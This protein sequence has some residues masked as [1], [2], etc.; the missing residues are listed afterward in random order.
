MKTKLFI[1]IAICYIA[2]TTCY[3]QSVLTTL[4]E[5]EKDAGTLHTF[6]YKNVYKTDIAGNIYIAGAT[7]NSSGNYDILLIKYNSKG[8]PQ[9]SQQYNGGANDA[10]SALTLDTNGNIYLTGSTTNSN[11]DIICFKFADDGTQTWMQTFNADANLDDYATDITLSQNN[12]IFITGSSFNNSGNTDITVLKYANDGTFN[13][14][15]H[16]NSNEELNDIGYKINLIDENV[17]IASTLQT[18]PIKYDYAMLCIKQ[19]NGDFYSIAADSSGTIGIDKVTDATIDSLGNI[20]ITGAKMNL[21]ANYD[22]YVV[23][24]DSNLVQ[25]WEQTYNGAE[26]LDDISNA[27]KVDSAGNVYITGYSSTST[28]GKNY[29]TL[30]YNSSGT[31]QWTSIYNNPDNTDD[32]ATAMTLG[33]NGKLYVTGSTHN[34]QFENDNFYTIR[35]NTTTGANTGAITWDS[36]Y[37]YNDTPTNIIIDNEQNI[38]VGGMSQTE[39]N[40]WHYVT[41]KYSEKE[42]LKPAE[43]L[44]DTINPNFSYYENKGQIITTDTANPDA[45]FVR[46]YTNNTY[47]QLYFQDNNYSMVF[48]SIDTIAATPDTLHRIDVSFDGAYKVHNNK[49]YAIDEQ[50][51]GY[52]NYFLSQ[53]P[54][55][56]TA[57]MPNQRLVVPELYKDIDLQYYSNQKGFKYCF[58]VKKGGDPNKI[59]HKFTGATSSTINANGNL[60][61]SSSIGSTNLEC[62]AYQVDNNNSIIPLNWNIQWNQV[63]SNYFSFDIGAYDSTKT[64]IIVVDEGHQSL[65]ITS[66]ANLEH[67]TYYG[68]FTRDNINDI[69]SDASG[70]VYTCGFTDDI[71]FPLAPGVN[72]FQSNNLGNYDATIVKFD[73]D[74]HLIWATY[75]GGSQEDVAFSLEI[76][77]ARNV[78][79]VGHTES[80]NFPMPST[81]VAGAYNDFSYNGLKDAY[82]VKL[83]SNAYIRQWA[84]FVGAS[85]HEQFRKITNGSNGAY[86]AVGYGT[87]ASPLKQNGNA[88]YS[89]QGGAYIVKF[90]A[91]DTITWAT[92]IPSTLYIYD[93]SI[94]K[95]LN[96]KFLIGTANGSSLPL[97]RQ[98][99]NS[100]VDSTINNYNDA[101][102]MKL[103][104][105][106]SLQWCT[107]YGG[108]L[109]EFGNGIHV[110][111]ETN[112]PEPSVYIVG[113][114]NSTDFPLKFNSGQFID[115]TGIATDGFIAKF[116]YFGARL[117]STYFGGDNLDGA[118]RVTGDNLGNIYVVGSTFSANLPLKHLNNAYYQ[119]NTFASTWSDGYIAAFN[120]AEQ[121]LWSTYLSGTGSDAPNG[122]TITPNNKLFMA[123]SS[124]VK[125]NFPWQNL[126][127]GAW[128]RDTL[129][130]YT[131]FEN[132]KDGYI[133]RL[134]TLPVQLVGI[135]EN[136]NPVQTQLLI[137]PNPN[138]GNLNVQ[139]NLSQNSDATI[140]IYSTLGQL[141]Y[142]HTL[143][144]KLGTIQEQIDVSKYANGVYFI[145]ID[146]NEKQLSAKIIKN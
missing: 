66:N 23:K 26:N 40:I 73:N 115:S 133:A 68:G 62:H 92:L 80:S 95:T 112:Q 48:A 146:T 84:S 5:W 124:D 2:A 126:G 119:T 130:G 104:P 41:V 33:N 90:N 110:R 125:Y 4:K 9:W 85:G 47:P 86:Y 132:Y 22:Y 50:K 127:N 11:A 82:V 108:S 103:A 118:Y 131:I 114:T 76:D 64:L 135:D 109:P 106:D 116:T 10:A 72:V 1:L 42:I 8:V 128:Y 14:A 45:G 69:K 18:S 37:H 20:Y 140:R 60:T 57:V 88:Y 75:Y 51:E 120:N 79:F 113:Q 123:G 19:N 29:V 12:S 143:K 27:L 36:K 24:L 107:Y 111:Q 139:F 102:I 137:Y 129:G 100:Y 3:S 83:D 101:F 34:K 74:M 89:N 49:I 136:N 35:Y 96:T 81:A 98:I 117:W 71:S 25:Q 55:G 21:F 70:N 61:V 121:I 138:S 122:L 63:Q 145:K 7:I 54:D 91:N 142:L 17:Y 43:Y 44:N 77:N 105:D 31:L 6:A 78:Y 30:K 15:T 94:E 99:L 87:S 32:I 134:S 59:T 67:C 144:N 46:F 38:I 65:Q 39:P 58:V 52:L 93:I 56:I 13:W 53:C 97:K 141:V 16:Y 28:Q